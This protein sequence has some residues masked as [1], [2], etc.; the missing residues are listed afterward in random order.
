MTDER[1][2]AS[3]GRG[4]LVMLGA[5]VLAVSVFLWPIGAALLA[6]GLPALH[7]RMRLRHPGVSVIAVLIV[8]VGA[9]L[10]VVAMLSAMFA[11]FGR[12]SQAFELVLMAAIYIFLFGSAMVGAIAAT[13]DV[14]P[15]VAGAL[16][17]VGGVVNAWLWAGE[18][19]EEPIGLVGRLVL[20]L[21]WAWLG[22][23]L[24]RAWSSRQAE[25]S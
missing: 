6:G 4:A 19:V 24:T 8:G 22:F 7:E 5:A 18:S 14:L 2:D 3:P 15:R 13:T 20:A 9:A 12:G 16:L 21:G 10:L 17:G 1:I 25:P 23:G 11:W